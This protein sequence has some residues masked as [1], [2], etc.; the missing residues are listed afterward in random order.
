MHLRRGPSRAL[1]G[2]FPRV[3]C[4]SAVITFLR[5]YRNRGAAAPEMNSRER[6][7][8]FP[9]YLLSRY[10]HFYV[11]SE[12]PCPRFVMRIGKKSRND[13]CTLKDYAL[14]RMVQTK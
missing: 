8:F 3:L 14:M 5:N 6:A 9:R 11:S 13:E 2:P 12:K 10:A 7:E 1:H 4:D